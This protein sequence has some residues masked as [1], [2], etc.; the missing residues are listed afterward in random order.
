MKAE[1]F[2]EWLGNAVGAVIRTIIDTL[3]VVL[4]SV[5]DVI[6]GF[7]AGLAQAIGMTP[8]AFNYTLLVIGLLLLYG[9]ARAF[10]QRSLVGGIILLVLA[11]LLL[12][13]L[14]R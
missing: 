4:G 13:G 5:G 12:G 11:V 2:S 7:S 6:S 14:I 1:S 9:A 8:S 3:Q 10:I